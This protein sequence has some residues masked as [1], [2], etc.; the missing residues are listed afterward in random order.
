MIWHELFYMLFGPVMMFLTAMT[1][2]WITR[3]A[4]TRIEP[5][6]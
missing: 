2:Y 1:V 4:K 6:E 3:P 5:G